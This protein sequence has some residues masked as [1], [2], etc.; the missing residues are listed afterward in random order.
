MNLHEIWMSGSRVPAAVWWLVLILLGLLVRWLYYRTYRDDPARHLWGLR[1]LAVVITLV[2]LADLTHKEFDV[3]LPQLI[4]AIDDSKS[5]GLP[6]AP[7][8]T[9][10][11]RL[12]AVRSVLSQQRL[13]QLAQR[14][15]LSIWRISDDAK[16]L[17]SEDPW[18]NLQANQDSSRLGNAIANI[19]DQQAG[20]NTAGMMVFSDGVA[21]SGMSMSQA[22]NVAR[23]QA[24][25]VFV[26]GTGSSE[27]LPNVKIGN[28]RA[29][30]RVRV[31]EPYRLTFDVQAD[32]LAGEQ[33]QLTVVDPEAGSELASR[34]ITVNGDSFR[35]SL[36]MEVINA[37]TGPRSLL[38]EASSAIEES[39][40]EDNRIEKMI[41][42]VPGGT[43]V[44]IIQD[45]PDPWFRFL[46]GTLV[47][48][49]DARTGAAAFEVH[50]LLQQATSEFSK[51]DNTALSRFPEPEELNKYDLVVIGDVQPGAPGQARGLSANSFRL[52]KE[53]VFQH[54]GNLVF[55]P[56]SRYYEAMVRQE[57]MQ[58]LLPVSTHR[59]ESTQIVEAGD[60]PFVFCSRPGGVSF[61]PVNWL[62][63]EVEGQSQF[64]FHAFRIP[65]PP[66]SVQ[67][68]VYFA[69]PSDSDNPVMPAITLQKI[70]GGTVVTHLTN[71]LFRLRYRSDKNRFENYWVR[72]ITDLAA[73][74]LQKQDKIALLNTNARR[75]L[76]GEPVEIIADIFDPLVDLQT[77]SS[78]PVLLTHND[79]PSESI[80]LR[81][82]FSGSARYFTTLENLSPGRYKLT[83]ATPALDSAAVV[84]EFEVTDGVLELDKLNQDT[85]QLSGLAEKSGGTYV[86]IRNSESVWAM[87]PRGGWNQVGAARLLP[88]WSGW[89]VPFCYAIL[90]IGLIVIEWLVR[91]KL[92]LE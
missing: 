77:T 28:L 63:Q 73:E 57:H 76:V 49:T 29:N 61:G 39:N 33:I 78:M 81:Q 83:L 24:V 2:A 3:E 22:G 43:R 52:L 7:D 40:Q 14:Y 69:S 70:A 79:N 86:D 47:R 58:A 65:D 30:Q 82:E 20:Q 54:A 11:S 36:S 88:I 27:A 51:I 5:A 91:R 60:Q 90:V 64:R 72:L 84:A 55:V 45:M 41:Q 68:L 71:E 9:S 23:E 74:R 50:T 80:S 19:L 42:V 26:V 67:T 66:A 59:G 53:Y 25:P 17:S 75:L 13:E 6:N 46:K 1:F 8:E 15:R 48:A 92:R 32:S 89:I 37:A 16:Q 21:T 35:R 87:L 85:E 4:I 56:G 12:D 62:M 18:Q 31:N 10:V 38:I 44:L 34:R